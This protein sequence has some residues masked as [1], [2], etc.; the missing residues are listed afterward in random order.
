M[1]NNNLIKKNFIMNCILTISS[2]LIPLITFPYV[3]RVLLPS[4][5]GKVS[6]AISVVDYFSLFVLLGIPIYGVRVVA[7]N[8][9]DKGKMSKSVIEILSINLIMFCIVAVFFLLFVISFNNTKEQKLLYIILGITL[10]SNSLGVEWLYKGLEK[11]TYITIRSLIFKLIALIGIFIFVRTQQD[12][13]WY[14]FFSVFGSIGSNVFNFIELH[15]YI[16]KVHV[17]IR[18]SFRHIKPIIIFFAMTVA[19]TIY[20]NLD[21]V[22]LG[23]MTSE[24]EVGY[25]STVV[26]VR[27]MLL[28]IVTSLGVVL[29]PRTSY[30]IQKKMYVEFYDVSK[31]TMNFV[32]ILAFP[33]AAFFILVAES[34]IYILS[35]REFI[36]ATTSLRLIL[37][38]IILIGITNLTGIQMLI[39]L[40]KEKVVLKSVVYGAI[41]DFFL[42][43]LLIPHFMASGAAIATLIAEVIVTL[44]QIK[45][46]DKKI[47]EELFSQRW[48]LLFVAITL[49]ALSADLITV[50]IGNI[51]ISFFVAG[52]AFFT[53]YYLILLFRKERMAVEI[54]KTLEEFVRK[55]I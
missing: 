47:I 7:Q 32:C 6:F 49:A 45:Q 48:G 23:I 46:F 41:V 18:D 50:L 24:T 35:G 40:N 10:L 3:S 31:K 13:L 15:K 21:N 36:P 42:N 43:L 8:R 26:K 55:F 33:L 9:E 37:P 53:I 14:A 27:N 25:Y 51:Y 16:D 20:T 12:Y 1:K 30:Y 22:M 38:T 2:F 52:V 29:L 11:Y 44:F 54:I 34:C 39:P 28:S 17:N 4:G 5:I 19:T